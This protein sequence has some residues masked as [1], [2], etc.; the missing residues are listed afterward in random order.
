MCSCIQLNKQKTTNNQSKSTPTSA[1]KTTN[2]RQNQQFHK[3]RK[4]L[5]TMW[6]GEGVGDGRGPLQLRPNPPFNA[7]R[8]HPVI[9]DDIVLHA[10]QVLSTVETNITRRMVGLISTRKKATVGPCDGFV[11]D[12]AD[13]GVEGEETLLIV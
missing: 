12:I 4:L 5:N 7:L 2:P 1:A 3:I 13:L 11:T 10:A 6:E 8:A 9:V